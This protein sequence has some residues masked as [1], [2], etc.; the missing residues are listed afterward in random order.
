M[1]LSAFHYQ[2]TDKDAKGK[3]VLDIHNPER[4]ITGEYDSLPPA[5][6]ATACKDYK[7]R[8]LEFLQGQWGGL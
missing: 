3:V 8:L 7:R 5:T 1:K 4:T 2:W 6:A